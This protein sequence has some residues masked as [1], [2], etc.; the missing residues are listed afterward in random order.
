MTLTLG[1]AIHVSQSREKIV[2]LS[3]T[4]SVWVFISGLNF[5]VSRIEYT[6]IGGDA[7][8]IEVRQNTTPS[9]T[10]MLSAEGS[11]Y[12]WPRLFTAARGCVSQRSFWKIGV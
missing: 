7:S 1:P 12:L 5:F 10:C 4:L 6:D 8:T 3:R 2:N 11:S 9:T